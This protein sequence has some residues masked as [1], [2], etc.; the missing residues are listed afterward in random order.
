MKVTVKHTQAVWETATMEVEVPD[1]LPE[2]YESVEEWADSEIA[3]I[4]SRTPIDGIH[5]SVG[6][7]V[8]GLDSEV[9]VVR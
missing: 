5:I 1:P 9:E 8:E 6:D 7:A 4:M 2:P 3:E